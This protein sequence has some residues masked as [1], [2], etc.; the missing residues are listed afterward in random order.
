VLPA[1]QDPEKRSVQH[2]TVILIPFAQKLADGR[3][4]R[5]RTRLFFVDALMRDGAD[6]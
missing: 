4:L 6:L 5:L 1:Y 3:N 2:Q